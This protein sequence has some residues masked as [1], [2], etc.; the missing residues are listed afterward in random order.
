MILKILLK[1]LA[2]GLIIALSIMC[3]LYGI[4]LVATALNIWTAKSFIF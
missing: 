4:E 2:I 3:V 1:E